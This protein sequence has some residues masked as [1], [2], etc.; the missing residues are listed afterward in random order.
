ML[1]TGVRTSPL[2]SL[3]IRS[4]KVRVIDEYECENNL[5]EVIVIPRFHYATPSL[6]SQEVRRQVLSKNIELNDVESSVAKASVFIKEEIEKN[7]KLISNVA[8]DEANLDAKIEKKKTDLDRSQKR[9]A[10]LKKVRYGVLMG[11]LTLLT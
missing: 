2:F 6:L 8:T 11:E 5:R 4:G 3:D 9:L 10:T 1:P 7:K